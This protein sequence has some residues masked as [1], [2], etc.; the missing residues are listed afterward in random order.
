MI[1]NYHQHLA[2]LAFI[3][4]FLAFLPNINCS[5]GRTK[6]TAIENRIQPGIIKNHLYDTLEKEKLNN[7][8]DEDIQNQIEDVWKIYPHRR[9]AA[10]H[11]M[12]G[13]R[14]IRTT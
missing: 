7:D 11:A 10:F 14:S 12:R 5:S 1:S 6:I 13:K 3:V 4:I 2:A 8:Y 9:A